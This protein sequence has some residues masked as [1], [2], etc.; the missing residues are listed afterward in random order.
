MQR[1]QN[2]IKNY[3]DTVN[4]KNEVLQILAGRPRS[5]KGEE[6]KEK[7]GKIEHQSS[8]LKWHNPL[9]APPDH[10]LQKVAEKRKSTG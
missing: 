2:N 9:C 10:Q 8:M 4:K 3:E 6:E 7:Q 1:A 5:Q